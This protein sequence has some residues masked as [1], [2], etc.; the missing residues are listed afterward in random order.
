VIAATGSWFG[1]RSFFL[2][3]GRP[4]VVESASTAAEDQF[5]VEAQA[6]VPAG[7]ATIRYEFRPDS[8]QLWAGGVLSIFVNGAQVG[9]GHIGRTIMTTAGI[10]ETFDIGRDTGEPVTSAYQNGGVFEGRIDKVEVTLGPPASP[11][12]AAPHPADVD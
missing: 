12:G 10:G 5:Q 9:S 4:V 1:G 7:D 2:D 3:H 11:G 6:P 8:G